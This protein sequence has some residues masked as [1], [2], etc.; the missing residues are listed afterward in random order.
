MVETI[1]PQEVRY[2]IGKENYQI[3]DLRSRQEYEHSHIKG[4]DNIS[5][6][7]IL[8]GDLSGIK[9]NRVILYCDRGGMSMRV[10]N[11]LTKKGYE[12]KNVVGGYQQIKYFSDMIKE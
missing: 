4:A 12:V 5:G 3:I 7:R 6:E 2:F 10:A 8:A 1:S 11:V 9:K